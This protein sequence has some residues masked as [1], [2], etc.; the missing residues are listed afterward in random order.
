MVPNRVEHPEPSTGRREKLA[1]VHVGHPRPEDFS[2]LAPALGGS[3]GRAF[4]GDE[5]LVNLE[6]V[7]VVVRHEDR[8][9][10]QRC[11]HSP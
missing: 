2:R 5:I 7:G 11:N 10:A 4:V 3:N 1:A 6:G 9:S 8:G